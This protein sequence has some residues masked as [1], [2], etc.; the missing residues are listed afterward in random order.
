MSVV[1][2]PVPVE[3]VGVDCRLALAAGLAESG[4]EIISLPGS[5]VPFF[6]RISPLGLGLTSGVLA[7]GGVEAMWLE[8][9]A[10]PGTSSWVGCMAGLCCMAASDFA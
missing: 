2:C 7:L 5:S 6:R 4:F 9:A 3:F 1:V 10:S 8:E